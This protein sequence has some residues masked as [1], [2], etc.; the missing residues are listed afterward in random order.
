MIAFS[1]FYR[2]S[3]RTEEICSELEKI[4]SGQLNADLGFVTGLMLELSLIERRPKRMSYF[5]Q[6]VNDRRNL[7]DRSSPH[8]FRQ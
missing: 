8:W 7:E 4:A 5:I 6:A 2:A 3:S 1:D